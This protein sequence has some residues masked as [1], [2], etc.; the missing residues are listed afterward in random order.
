MAPLGRS[1]SSSSVWGTQYLH[2]VPVASSAALSHALS[3]GTRICLH[4]WK[5]S[6]V[7]FA[8]DPVFN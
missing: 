7:L 1:C 4:Y 6:S 3:E 8:Q 2:G 5:P